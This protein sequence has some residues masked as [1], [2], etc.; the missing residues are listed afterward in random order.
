ML[1]VVQEM[2]AASSSFMIESKAKQ[3]EIDALK[4]KCIEDAEML[5]LQAKC[6]EAER[7]AN[8]IEMIRLKGLV[9]FLEAEVHKSNSRRFEAEEC[10]RRHSLPKIRWSD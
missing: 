5:N 3:A 6:A 7:E 1:Q 9:V 2:N 8:R 10:L 4:A